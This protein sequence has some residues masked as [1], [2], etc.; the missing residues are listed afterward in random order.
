MNFQINGGTSVI[1]MSLRKNAPY[2]DSIKDDDTIL[3]YE[4]H[5]LPKNLAKIPKEVD[6]PRFTPSGILTQN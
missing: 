3:I 6:Q 1:L 5:D 4:G 2:A